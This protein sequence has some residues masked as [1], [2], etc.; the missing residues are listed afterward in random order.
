MLRR[1]SDAEAM[2]LLAEN[3]KLRLKMGSEGRNIIKNN[4]KWDLSVNN[5]IKIYEKATMKTK[6]YKLSL[7]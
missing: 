6:G 2:I 1:N 4:Y 3:E 7:R 5:M